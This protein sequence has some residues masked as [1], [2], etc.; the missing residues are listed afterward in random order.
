MKQYSIKFK[1]FI[2]L[3]IKDVFNFF[4]KPENLTLITPPRL[5]FKILTSTPVA[6]HQG[7]SIDYVLT[8][9]YVFKIHWTSIIEAYDKPNIF[10]DRQIK[11]PYSF[12]HHTHTFK[13]KGSGTIITDKLIYGIPFGLIGRLINFIDF[14][15]AKNSSIFT[16]MFCADFFPAMSPSKQTNGVLLK[17]HI[18][19]I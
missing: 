9:M 11:G 13:T 10:I 14:P 6:M 8:I 4:S 17:F 3:P 2:D 7:Q 18:L 12:W 1:Q 15:G 5:Q 16:A 19:N